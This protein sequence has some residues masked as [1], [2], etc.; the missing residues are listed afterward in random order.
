MCWLCVCMDAVWHLLARVLCSVCRGMGAG[1]KS[2]GLGCCAVLSVML[3]MQ[4]VPLVQS[5]C[6]AGWSTPALLTVLLHGRCTMHHVEVQAASGLRCVRW[7]L[8]LH[9]LV[10][11]RAGALL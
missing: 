4:R 6:V 1:T 3:A 10:A 2:R 11:V 9:G 7:C 5:A 8:L